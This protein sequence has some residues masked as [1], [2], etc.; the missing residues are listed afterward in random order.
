MRR[1]GAQSVS[2]AKVVSAKKTFPA[3]LGDFLDRFNLIIIG[4]GGLFLLLGWLG[5]MAFDWP[6]VVVIVLF[7]LSY[8]AGGI[9]LMRHAV[10]AVVHGKFDTDVLMLAAALGAAFLGAWV[11]GAFLLFLFGLGH[12]GENYALDR[13]RNAVNKLGELMPKI[14]RVRRNGKIVTM[15]VEEL[16]VGE[17]VVVRPGDRIAVDGKIIQGESAID[18]SPI[19]GESMPVQKRARG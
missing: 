18:Q 10:P 17:V 13:A 12:A 2:T 19:T 11:E 16:M 4:V 1:F 6:K 3:V 7:L 14:A 8:L 15:P 9:D 5:D